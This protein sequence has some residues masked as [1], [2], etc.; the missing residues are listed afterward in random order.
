MAKSSHDGCTQG[1][2]KLRCLK[3]YVTKAIGIKC[4]GGSTIDDLTELNGLW[5]SMYK[6]LRP[7]SLFVVKAVGIE[8]VVWLAFLP[9]SSRSPRTKRALCKDRMYQG[10]EASSYFAD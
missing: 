8:V 6:R 9:V 2:G 7:D 4:Q 1:H 5:N 10:P 3:H